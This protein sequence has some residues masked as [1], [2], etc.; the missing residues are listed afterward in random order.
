MPATVKKKSSPKLHDLP[1]TDIRTGPRQEDIKQS[2]LDNLFYGMG[3]VPM[4]ATPAD[5]TLLLR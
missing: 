4:A 2:Y 1:P 5:I 3:R